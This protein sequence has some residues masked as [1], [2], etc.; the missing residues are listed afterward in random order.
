MKFLLCLFAISLTAHAAPND[1]GRVALDFLEKVR[2]GKLDLEPGGDT[3]LS[4]QTV[5]SKRR[6][7]AKNLERMARDLGDDPLEV[8]AVKLDDNF[9]A[10]LVRKVGGFDPNRL[11]IFPV[12]LVR[13]GAEWAAAPVPASF[14]NS[15]TGYAIE[16]RKRLE[17]L[18][19]WMLRQQVT[20]LELLREQ[21]AGRMREKIG[22]RLPAE[23]VRNMNYL[24]ITSHFMT[25]C[26]QSDT[27]SLLGLLG[28]LA[29]KLPDDW[30]A[31][32]RA[33]ENNFTPSAGA[34]RPWRLLVSPDVARV[35]V[36]HDGGESSGSATIACLD[37]AGTDDG[38]T[39][40]RIELIDIGISRA[41]DGLWQVNPPQSFFENGKN[42]D[43]DP[44]EGDKNTDLVNEFPAEWIK[45]NPLKPAASAEKAQQALTE[46]LG[47]GHFPTLL[48][49]AN[50]DGES[51]DGARKACIEAAKIGWSIQNPSA[52][53]KAV[54][55]AFK[56]GESVAVGIYHFFS[57]REP[58]HFEPREL[59]FEKSPSGWLWSPRPTIGT[60][61]QLQE[62][63]E[64]ESLP[65]RD[66]WQQVLL[67]ESP[68]IQDI[69]SLKAPSERDSRQ[70]VE[71]WL[72]ESRTGDVVSALHL[73]ARLND[74]Q[75]D[76]TVLRNLGYEITGSRRDVAK[77]AITGIYQGKT[78][79]AVG[80]R[81]D[82]GK[83]S[84]FPLYPVLQTANGPRIII[85]IDLFAS[86]NRGREFL[87]KVAMERLARLTSTTGELQA[88]VASHQA[89][90][91]TLENKAPHQD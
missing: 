15:G 59:Y 57:A 86:E 36:T 44:G 1:P 9:A 23:N 24:E 16:L 42:P 73:V 10:V 28:G 54:P 84:T 7:I 41:D 69:D 66:Q 12:A 8:G 51:Q 22:K 61:K 38:T 53:C 49:L 35:I 90:V 33:I 85:E 67:V 58:D 19:N 2:L 89:R 20:D 52:I 18:E 6:Q 4:A 30:P 79:T 34:R 32:L 62:W 11:R 17:L 43:D 39:P 70:L 71:K 21:S 77:P 26:E 48:T 50:I 37:P 72:Q 55:L 65:L 47:N 63:I 78:W 81:V 5:V 87:N 27:I 76:S 14:E 68:V 13:R 80:V 64:A 40:P 56:A 46:A 45:S 75:S 74:P 83:K 25:A 3:A 31:R 60:R 29:T 91:E 88:L 82:Q